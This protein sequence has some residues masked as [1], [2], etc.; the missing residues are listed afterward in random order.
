[1][2][3]VEL[4]YQRRPPQDRRNDY[5]D[6]RDDSRPP[7]KNVGKRFYEDEDWFGWWPEGWSIW[8]VFL[9]LLFLLLLGTTFGL[10]LWAVIHEINEVEPIVGPAGPPGPDGASGNCTGSC[11]NGTNGT[12]GTDGTNGA[13]AV[14]NYAMFFGQTAGTGMIGT[15]YAATVA[16]KTS[17]G[18]GR[19][20]FPQ[21]GVT[22]A[23]TVTRI[24]AT[25]FQ[26]G[27][28]GDYEVS[29]KVHTTEPGQ[30]QLELDGA[31]L[32]ETAT[33]N[34]NP[35]SGGHPIVGS[36]L[37]TVPMG[38]GVLA[39]VNPTGNAAALTITPADGSNTHANAQNIVIKQLS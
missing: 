17:A 20:P 5:D 7:Y 28:P 38:G 13:N 31:D 3:S 37:I 6:R 29:F 8:V 2:T 26:L 10:S 16:V 25:S 14:V 30:L 11:V 34:M 15:D 4:Q 36:F 22:S 35:T 9:G 21:D 24:D 33:A 12:N 32:V 19:V 18:T 1:M 39:L 27:T 23:G